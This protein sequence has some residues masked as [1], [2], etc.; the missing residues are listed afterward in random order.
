M[1]SLGHNTA[2]PSDKPRNPGTTNPFDPSR[3][4]LYFIAY[5]TSL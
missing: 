5:R 3:P 4:S 2:E 1:D